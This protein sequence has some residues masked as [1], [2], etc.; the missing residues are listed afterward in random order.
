M[1]ILISTILFLSL[2]SQCYGG[3]LSVGGAEMDGHSNKEGECIN[4]GYSIDIGYDWKL[5][6]YNPIKYLG[7][8]ISAGG[9][10]TYSNYETAHREYKGGKE[11]QQE[12]ESSVTLAGIIRPTLH[13]WKAYA[14]AMYGAGPDYAET[15]KFD[16]G[17]LEG[18]GIGFSVTNNVS[19][20]ISKRKFYRHDTGNTKH[21][22]VS[23]RLEF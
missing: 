16:Y 12:R 2:V 14:F 11:T 22:T 4:P 20:E 10:F 6:Q 23:L 1:K 13:V 18:K 7:V 8:S 3:V 5:L 21:T 19:I 15:D 17:W 9:L